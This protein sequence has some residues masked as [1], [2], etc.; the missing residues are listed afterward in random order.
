MDAVADG[1]PGYQQKGFWFLGLGPEKPHSENPVL[2][3]WVRLAGSED[4][5]QRLANF[6]S[7]VVVNE[8]QFPEAIHEEIDSRA[9]G[10]DHLCQ[11]LIT[12][13]G[14]LNSRGAVLIEAR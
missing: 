7:S 12:Q 1:E 14:N 11:N 8:S 4:F 2:K 5:P 10:A 3:S 13:S 9:R 6:Q